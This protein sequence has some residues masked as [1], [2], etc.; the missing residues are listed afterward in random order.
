MAPD[1]IVFFK[2]ND[3][4]E[5]RPKRVTN[6]YHRRFELVVLEK[7]GPIHIGEKSYLLKPCEAAL[8]FPN[9]FHHYMDVAPSE[10]EWLFITFELGNAEPIASLKNA[11][12]YLASKKWNSS[13]RSCTTIST[14][15][16]AY[17]TQ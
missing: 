1:N 4:T 11:R 17:R 10:I 6:N 2:R 9:Q 16:A 5:L 15:R 12:G 13:G 7:V 14:P 3:T 8:I